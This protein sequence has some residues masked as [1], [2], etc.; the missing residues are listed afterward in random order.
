M[1]PLLIIS[2]TLMLIIPD[3]VSALELHKYWNLYL[4][5][6]LEYGHFFPQDDDN[7]QEHPFSVR[8]DILEQRKARAIHLVRVCA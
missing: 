4:Y 5:S 6:M 7:F 2:S 1:K 8:T 3:K